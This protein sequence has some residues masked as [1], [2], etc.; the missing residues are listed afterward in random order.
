MKLLPHV[1]MSAA[2]GSA[3]WAVTRD[4]LALPAALGAGVLP[5]ADH[6][7]DY[8][9]WYVRRDRSRVILLLHGWEYLIAGIVVYAAWLHSPWMLAAILGY[10]SQVIADW[11]VHDSTWLT[12]SVLWRAW[13][14]FEAVKTT[15]KDPA[16]AYISFVESVPFG[17]KWLH[18]WFYNRLRP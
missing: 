5:D 18:R 15:T 1:A 4:P 7:I 13:H 12:Y 10:A 11:A 17:R 3:L 6:L 8:F 16:F 2:I 9:N 14:R